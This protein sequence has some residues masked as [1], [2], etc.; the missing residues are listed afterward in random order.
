[1]FA[2]DSTRWNSKWSSRGEKFTADHIWAK[3]GDNYDLEKAEEIEGNLEEETEAESFVSPETEI[4]TRN[5]PTEGSAR[6][7]SAELQ[8][9]TRFRMINH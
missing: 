2:F 3:L 7:S 8:A 4:C 6:E 5:N 9:K 1:M